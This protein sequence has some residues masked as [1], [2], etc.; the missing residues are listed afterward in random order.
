MVLSFS[1]IELYRLQTG[2]FIIIN[3]RDNMITCLSKCIVDCLTNVFISYTPIYFQCS[4]VHSKVFILHRSFCFG[5]LFN[6]IKLIFNTMI[7]D[8]LFREFVSTYY[9]LLYNWKFVNI[10]VLNLVFFV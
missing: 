5:K 7:T 3:N 1:L 10:Y 4:M 6:I 8:N 2:K 9:L